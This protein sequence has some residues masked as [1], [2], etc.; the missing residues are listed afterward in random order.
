MNAT[1]GAVRHALLRAG[2]QWPGVDLDGLVASPAGDLTLRTA[3]GVAPPS[4]RP[5]GAVVPSGLAADRSC[6]LYVADTSGNRVLRVALDCH[7]RL[8][9]PGCHPSAPGTFDVP[10]GLAIGPF[11]WLYVADGGSGRILVLT[12]PELGIRDAWS[13]RLARPAGVAGDGDLGV[14]V[15]DAG[16]S[17]VRRFGPDGHLDAGFDAALAAQGPPDP[18]AIAVDEAGTVYVADAARA[19]VFRFDRAGRPLGPPLAV[20]LQGCALAVAAGI[21]YL[22]DAATGQVILVSLPDGRRVG[23]VA[24]FSGPVAALAVTPGGTVFIK[25]DAGAEWITARPGTAF[26]SSGSLQPMAP[27]DAGEGSAWLRVKVSATTDEAGQVTLETCTSDQASGPPTWTAAAATATL[28]PPGRYLWIRVTVVTRD[29]ASSPVVR[30]VEAET[31]GDSYLDHLPAVYGREPALADFLIRLLE[32]ARFELGGLE[33][34][35]AALPGRFDPATAP[36]DWLDWLA[37]WQ[38]FEVPPDLARGRRPDSMRALLARLPE[39]Y[40]RRGTPAGLADAVE[41][42]TGARPLLLEDFRAR[43]VWV[44]DQASALGFDTVLPPAAPDGLVVGEAVVGESRPEPASAWAQDLFTDTAHRFTVVLPAAM[45]RDDATRR[46]LR[47]VLDGEKPA[48]TSYH[49]CLP[50]PSLRVGIQARVGINTI[51]AGTGPGLVLDEHA[52]LDIDA[53]LADDPPGS[54]GSVGQRARVGVD[55]RLG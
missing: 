4:V 26:G 8:L 13:G 6:G 33:A 12:T 51:I 15:L 30:Q 11:G 18:R 5:A 9:F 44:L 37:G 27:L 3:P 34:V 36:A 35:V 16:A 43:G 23:A 41:I 2:Q 14:V 28:L 31:A 47:R 39:L 24:G 21:L 29:P 53:R 7:D 20:G 42:Y 25:P 40:G 10:A 46:Q 17:R 1:S 54:S 45:A 52:S 48:H 38:A 49:L 22:A 55:T 50:G 19:A 32:L